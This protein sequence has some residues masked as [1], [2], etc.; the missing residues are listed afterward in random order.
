MAGFNAK[1]ETNCTYCGETVR[2]SEA[3]RFRVHRQ[4]GGTSYVIC[5]R[6]G[7]ADEWL[8]SMRDS[9]KRIDG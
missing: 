9:G 7:C 8:D 6:D 5:H 2:K 4:N 3:R 1:R